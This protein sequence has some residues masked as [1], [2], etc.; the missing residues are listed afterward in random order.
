[1]AVLANP[2]L[3]RLKGQLAKNVIPRPKD[4]YNRSLQ[5]DGPQSEGYLNLMVDVWILVD[6]EQQDI[7]ENGRFDLSSL[8]NKESNFI[9]FSFYER[10]ASFD[11]PFDFV[12]AKHLPH[13]LIK[14]IIAAIKTEGSTLAYRNSIIAV[15]L[16]DLLDPSQ[17]MQGALNIFEELRTV[18]QG[19]QELKK[20]AAHFKGEPRKLQEL[21]NKIQVPMNIQF[22]WL[23]LKKILSDSKH[24]LYEEKLSLLDRSYFKGSVGS[25]IQNLSQ[26][27]LHL[28]AMREEIAQKYG[29]VTVEQ[30]RGS[31]NDPFQPEDHAATQYWVRLQRLP[32]TEVRKKWNAARFQ[33]RLS[34]LASSQVIQKNAERLT[35]LLWDLREKISKSMEAD[36]QVMA[37]LEAERNFE[38]RTQSD[39]EQ[40]VCWLEENTVKLM[41]TM[42]RCYL[43]CELRSSNNPNLVFPNE[44]EVAFKQ[45]T[46]VK[47][48]WLETDASPLE[49]E[50]LNLSSFVHGSANDRIR[51]L[52]ALNGKV[53]EKI[54]NLKPEDLNVWLS[55]VRGQPDEARLETYRSSI[56]GAHRL[57]RLRQAIMKEVAHSFQDLEDLQLL[58]PVTVEKCLDLSQ[59]LNIHRF[60]TL[61][62]EDLD[63][64]KYRE[65]R[66]EAQVCEDPGKR[67]LR[68]YILF[69]TLSGLP[70]DSH[71]KNYLNTWRQDLSRPIFSEFQEYIQNNR[72]LLERFQ[73]PLLKVMR[74]CLEETVGVCKRVRWTAMGIWPLSREYFEEKYLSIENDILKI[75]SAS[76]GSAVSKSLSLLSKQ[77]LDAQ[78]VCT[79][80]A[81]NWNK[82]H[83]KLS[84]EELKGTPFYE[85]FSREFQE[86]GAALLK[87]KP[88]IDQAHY[89]ARKAQSRF[90]E[91]SELEHLKLSLSAHDIHEICKNFNLR[92]DCS[93][94]DVQLFGSAYRNREETFKATL[95][96]SNEKAL[97]GTV[98]SKL[99]QITNKGKV[100]SLTAHEKLQLLMSS[101]KLLD[102]E[103]LL[104][105]RLL[106]FTRT[107]LIMQT[108]TFLNI[109]ELFQ[110]VQKSKTAAEPLKI[111]RNILVKKLEGEQ[112]ANFRLN[113]EVNLAT[114]FTYLHRI[115]GDR[116]EDS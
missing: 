110:L 33:E 56:I 43:E 95:K 109:L 48:E 107:N 58:E 113:Y 46:Y 108:Q 42:H 102:A 32:F 36:G 6:R 98:F 105:R 83:E 28:N 76:A 29:L 81:S 11:L 94:E 116:L 88:F 87:I 114:F 4:L 67:L 101:Q 82:V 53:E 44:I 86:N 22:E 8:Q 34:R 63:I 35:V 84:L 79:P 54:G 24:A 21:M 41:E 77:A 72:P 59:K 47:P 49:S 51:A 14:A 17:S 65:A 15:Q 70:P 5:I 38:I 100:R 64:S 20:E 90:G 71:L 7:L 78:I 9:W 74:K 68:L 92:S 112:P 60:Q 26:V 1:M 2:L 3:N 23:I 13:K 89:R 31:K 96:E 73:G 10:S 55:H 104:F 39:F 30:T 93:Q 16:G 66:Q 106:N 99:T 80:E 97:D 40:A 57:T 45:N 52:T 27:L 19:M 50:F 12:F 103:I 85:T 111:F 61:D 115:I 69:R 37:N 91:S 18:I 75:S 62:L 25:F